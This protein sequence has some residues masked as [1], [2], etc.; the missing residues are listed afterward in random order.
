MST[1]TLT[2]TTNN[3]ASYSIKWSLLTILCFFVITI[4]G[5]AVLSSV[6]MA[7]NDIAGLSPQ[8]IGVLMDKDTAFSIYTS[9]LGTIAALFCGWLVT[10]K[11]AANNYVGAI[12]IAILLASYG[13][14]SIFMH[15]DH[16]MLHQVRKLVPPFLVCSFGAWLAIKKPAS[17]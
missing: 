9:L 15:P 17:H 4:I 6:W 2:N 10:R 12:I 14:L 13:V 11:T 8:Q 3:Q 1:Q 7:Q 16:H 5:A